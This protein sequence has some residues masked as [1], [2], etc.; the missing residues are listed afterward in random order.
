[1]LRGGALLPPPLLERRLLGSAARQ[2]SSKRGPQRLSAQRG[3]GLR[4][5][6][7]RLRLT[8]VPLIKL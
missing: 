7:E 1:M 4:V 6:A 3:C 5:L 2:G 8:S